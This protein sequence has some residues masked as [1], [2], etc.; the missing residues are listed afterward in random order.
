LLYFKVCQ[1]YVSCICKVFWVFKLYS[2]S[3]Y[4]CIVSFVD[5]Y[6]YIRSLPTNCQHKKILFIHIKKVKT[7]IKKFIQK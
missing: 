3:T 4:V 6:T 5:L 7:N 2:P 1:I